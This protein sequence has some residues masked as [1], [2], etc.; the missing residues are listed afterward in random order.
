MRSC[1]RLAIWH[2]PSQE[3]NLIK[4][5]SKKLIRSKAISR[6]SILKRNRHLEVDDQF[7]IS[8]QFKDVS[9]R[10]V[11]STVTAS[12]AHGDGYSRGDDFC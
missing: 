9:N 2:G 3:I 8:F 5:L 7:N 10:T 11:T 6:I 4:I 1:A 12:V